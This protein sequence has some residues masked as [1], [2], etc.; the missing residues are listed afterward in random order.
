MKIASPKAVRNRL[1][2]YARRPCDPAS[3]GDK[4][5]VVGEFARALE[6]APSQNNPDMRRYLVWGFC[7][8]PDDEQ[9]KRFRSGDLTDGQVFALKKWIGF[10]K[11]HEDEWDRRAAF[12]AEVRQILSMAETLD[13]LKRQSETKATTMGEWM[14]KLEEKTYDVEKAGMVSSADEDMGDVVT[15]E[16]EDTP[17]YQEAFSRPARPEPKPQETTESDRGYVPL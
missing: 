12:K 10:F 13:F 9:I 8:T 5:A 11:N 3:N 2:E 7:F 16:M 14:D 6:S 17:E 4:G 1:N 15:G